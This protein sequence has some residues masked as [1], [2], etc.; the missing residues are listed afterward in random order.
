MSQQQFQ[1]R[2][3]AA[4]RRPDERDET[5]RRDAEFNITQQPRIVLAVAIPQ[6]LEF[7]HA[8]ERLQIGLGRRLR[9][10][11]TGVGQPVEMHAQ[12]L[13]IKQLFDELDDVPGEMLLVAHEREQHADGQ[14]ALHDEGGT[15]IDD[16]DV[17]QAKH[18][19]IE[20]V[21]QQQDLG[22]LDTAVQRVRMVALPAMQPRAFLVIGANR[23][24]GTHRLQKTGFFLRAGT[25]LVA[26]RAF[27]PW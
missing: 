8:G 14:C 24:N 7:E 15:E 18:Q 13:E 3:L 11:E 9:R 25:N 27:E 10:G 17:L 2:R 16:Q 26:C 5:T 4:T 6:P 22:A 19:G 21:P 23:A 1:Q 20:R 12:Q